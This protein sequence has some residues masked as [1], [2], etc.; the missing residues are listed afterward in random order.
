[1]LVVVTYAKVAWGGRWTF[2]R[3]AVGL[4]R[5]MSGTPGL[6]AHRQGIR[7]FGAEVWTMTAWQS[8]DSMRAF[9]RG[10]A[11]AAARRQ[12]GFA[13]EAMS[14][15]QLDCAVEQIPLRWSD[16]KLLRGGRM[17]KG[18][19]LREPEPPDHDGVTKEAEGAARP[20]DDVASSPN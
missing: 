18:C 2:S 7:S 5:D 9:V 19:A 16:V 4:L 13:I 12:A 14:S 20:P 6:I 11:H 15:W 17:P 10:P 1:M 8:E 3:A